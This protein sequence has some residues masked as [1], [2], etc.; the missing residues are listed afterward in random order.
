MKKAMM[1]IMAAVAIGSTTGQRT[2]GINAD[3]DIDL[4]ARAQRAHVNAH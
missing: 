3:S 4:S 2:S 1:I